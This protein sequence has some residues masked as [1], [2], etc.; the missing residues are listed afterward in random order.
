MESLIEY[1]TSA[2]A[3]L[4]YIVMF[5]AMFLEGDVALLVLGVLVHMGV[6]PLLGAF[7]AGY[8]GGFTS[9][10]VWFYIGRHIQS[11][12]HKLI[13]WIQRVTHRPNVHI[14]KH[15]FKSL[16]FTKFMYGVLGIHRAVLIRTGMNLMPI[17]KFI[18]LNGIADVIWAGVLIATG[19]F[20]GESIDKFGHVAK[21]VQIVVFTLLTSVFIILKIRSYIEEKRIEVEEEASA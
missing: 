1:A 3:L 13:H 8:L 9:D 7:L 17:K 11:K 12:N 14:R 2:P 21:V 19:Y 15:Q 5:A 20:A 16:L 4:I 18:F 6:L 10:S